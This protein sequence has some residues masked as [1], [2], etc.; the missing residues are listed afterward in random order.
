MYSKILCLLLLTIILILLIL[1]GLFIFYNILIF[2][3]L[4]ISGNISYK[5]LIKMI[6]IVSIDNFF[7]N[8][9]LWDENHSNLK[10][11]NLNLIQ[12]VLDKTKLLG[13]TNKEILDVGCGYGEQDFI[14]SQQLD[15]SCKITAIDISNEQIY[16]A[17]ERANNK[18]ITSIEFEICDAMF[19]N[20]KYKNKKFDVVISIESAFH[21]SDRPYFF[22]NVK[23]ILSNDGIFVITDIT[24]KNNYTH[25][26]LTKIF[27]NIYSNSISFPKQN[28]ITSDEWDKQLKTEFDIV[29]IHDLT[30]KTY[31]S[32]YIHFMNTF[33]TN[34]KLPFCLSKMLVYL[35]TEIQPFSYR[36]AVCKQRKTNNAD[37]N[38]NI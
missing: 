6:N 19:I 38:N 36:C 10:D 31:S 37:N 13:E 4:R 1:L 30:D 35:F 9:G 5:Y 3:Y 28:L 2:I 17:I 16:N 25:D 18:N 22:R 14:F 21:Y 34:M 8:Y 27:I 12:F 15:K 7:M 11:A 29:E 26:L 23:E 24:L 32:Y 33:V 20:K